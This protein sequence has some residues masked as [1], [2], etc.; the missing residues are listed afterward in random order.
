MQS[1]DY[2]GAGIGSGGRGDPMGG[3][4]GGGN[5]WSANASWGGYGSKE[6]L[7]RAMSSATDPRTGRGWSDGAYRSGDLYG[8]D[9]HGNVSKIGTR[10]RLGGM[11]TTAPGWQGPYGQVGVGNKRHS[12]YQGYYTGLQQRIKD[13]AAQRAKTEH[14]A[15]TAVRSMDLDPVDEAAALAAVNKGDLKG[16]R[17]YGVS[18]A[19]YEKTHHNGGM[20]GDLFGYVGDDVQTLSETDQKLNGATTMSY[21]PFGYGMLSTSPGIAK[22]LTE[23]TKSP[24]AGFA[25]G[26]VVNSTAKKVGPSTPDWSPAASFGMGMLGIPGASH[27]TQMGGLMN[28]AADLNYAGYTGSPKAPGQTSRNDAPWRYSGGFLA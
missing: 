10:S 7:D 5:S 9:R 28:Q 13:A 22:Q 26:N 25:G 18:T 3:G 19:G 1:S 11:M 4:P 24:V 27:I 14:A 23:I 6:A 16:M 15:R 2:G 8:L 12:S 21:S 17:D 20:L